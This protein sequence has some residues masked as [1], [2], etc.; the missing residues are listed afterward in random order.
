MKLDR[1]LV[2]AKAC[3]GKERKAEIDCCG[4]ERISGCFQFYTEAFLSIQFSP[5]ADEHLS[6]VRE[7]TPI[8]LLVGVGERGSRDLGANAGMV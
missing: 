1:A 4:V 5:N 6:E 2:L 7:D 3:P 8:A